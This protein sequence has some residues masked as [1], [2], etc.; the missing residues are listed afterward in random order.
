MIGRYGR[1]LTALRSPPSITARP[2]TRRTRRCQGL[3][4]GRQAVTGAPARRWRDRGARRPGSLDR[5]KGR[6]LDH[7]RGYCRICPCPGNPRPGGSDPDAG[8]VAA[9]GTASPAQESGDRLVPGSTSSSSRSPSR[10]APR[11]LGL[12][13]MAASSG[14]ISSSSISSGGPID[15]ESPISRPVSSRTPHRS[16]DGPGPVGDTQRAGAGT[17][18]GSSLSGRTDG[19]RWPPPVVQ[20]CS[21]ADLSTGSAATQRPMNVSK[22]ATSEGSGSMVSSFV[23]AKTRSVRNRSRVSPGSRVAM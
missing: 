10:H 8:S 9:L 12:V 20:P 2:V 11:S 21:T 22:P 13:G 18:A 1:G 19:W 14:P 4:A 15:I 6:P 16:P 23:P 7:L 5:P 17:P 3:S